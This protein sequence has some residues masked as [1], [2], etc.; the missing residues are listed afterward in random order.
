[1]KITS[2]CIALGLLFF[3]AFAKAQRDTTTITVD[4][5][6]IVMKASLGV[7]VPMG[8]V[9][10]E[11]IEVFEDS[12]CPSDVQC[13]WAG[14]V[15]LAIAITE[16]QK[17]TIEKITFGQNNSTMLYDRDGFKIY[18]KGVLPYPKTSKKIDK[19]EY[20]ILVERLAFN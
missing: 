19:G 20:A 9:T 8:D 17:T 14:H 5:P 7:P 12:R 13:I 1:M 10:V 4:V 2:T 15:K 3:S 11:L 18:L 6:K 16:N